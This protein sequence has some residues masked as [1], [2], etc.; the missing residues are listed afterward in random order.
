MRLDGR[1]AE[2]AVARVGGDTV[3]GPLRG[4]AAAGGAATV[5]VPLD[6]VRAL[7]TRRFSAA[8]TAGLAAGILAAWIALA[9][10]ALSAMP[11]Y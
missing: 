6:S 7:H 2:L 11:V 3:R 10:A 5:V 4:R 8:R 1:R 9:Y